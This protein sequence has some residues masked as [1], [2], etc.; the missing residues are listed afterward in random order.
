MK[1]YVRG[2]PFFESAKAREGS[3]TY[4]GA[5]YAGGPL[6]SDLLRGQLVLAQLLQ[7]VNEQVARFSLGG[8]TFVRLVADSKATDSP[9]RTSLY[10]LLVDGPVRPTPAGALG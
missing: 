5:T 9:L 1:S 3:I 7:P 10:D 6:R 4:G 2:H 8:H